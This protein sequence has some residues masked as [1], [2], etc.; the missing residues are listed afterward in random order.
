M[1]RVAGTQVIGIERSEV[2]IREAQKQ[3]AHEGEAHLLDMRQGDVFKPPIA[4]A[5]WGKFDIA[6]TRFLLEHLRDPLGAVRNMVR[7]VRPGGRIILADDDFDT[8]RLWP[9]P[10][11]FSTIWNAHNRTYDRHGNDPHVG[12]RL[13]QLLHQAGAAPCFNTLVFFGSCAGQP[14]FGL[15]IRNVI[16]VLEEAAA[17]ISETGLTKETISRALLELETWSTSPDAALWYGLYWAEGTRV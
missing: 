12:R 5:E 1:A 16:A 2:Q 10:P 11:G 3:A 8:L 15:F 7:S 13:V 14:E 17:D 4:E 9:E 6:H